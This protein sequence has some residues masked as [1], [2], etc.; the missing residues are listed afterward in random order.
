MKDEKTFYGLNYE[1]FFQIVHNLYDEIWVYD[2]EYNMVYVNKACKRHYGLEPEEIIGK[3]FFDMVDSNWWSPSILPHVYDEKKL[4]AIKQTTFLGSELIN[5]ANPIFDDK[6]NLKFVAMSV[7]DS[8]ENSKLFHPSYSSEDLLKVD[9]SSIMFSSKKMQNVMALAKK[10]SKVDSTCLITGE[11]GTGKTMLASYIHSISPR[12]EKPFIIINC[13]TIPNEL[14]ESELFGYVKGAFTGARSDGKIG[15]LERANGGTV[16]L[17]EIAE[18]PFNIQAKLLHVI[19]EKEFFPVG[20]SVPKKVDIKIIAATNRD[21]NQLVQ[22][23]TFREDLYYRLNIFEVFMPP[24]RE[25]GEDVDKLIYYF[26]NQFSNKYQMHHEISDAAYNILKSFSWRGNV[27][28]LS[29]IIERLVVT[30]DDIVIDKHHLPSHLFKYSIDT[31]IVPSSVENVSSLKD[32][33]SSY[34][35]SIVEHAYKKYKTTRKIA[36]ALDI[37]QTKASTLVRKYIT[38]K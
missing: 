30:V 21:L 13:S 19:Q 6:G 8:L 35:K 34:E 7:R 12:K 24:L 2:N 15:L 36:E 28:E 31:N 9:A 33:M 37:T 10:I 18:L 17:D 3:N 4:Y 25:R 23:E 22:N 5:I 16:L 32:A 14:L 38:D 27:R 11:S 1:T 29:H 20:A 26:L